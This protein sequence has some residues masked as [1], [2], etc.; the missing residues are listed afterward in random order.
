MRGGCSVD[1][2]Q[3]R[4]WSGLRGRR[5]L[6]TISRFLTLVTGHMGGAGTL[7]EEEAGFG[8]EMTGLAVDVALSSLELP[9]CRST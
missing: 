1:V 9:T 2:C 8:G 5:T 6:R 7:V 3:V 4:G